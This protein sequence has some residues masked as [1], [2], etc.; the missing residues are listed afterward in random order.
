[1]TNPVHEETGR[2]LFAGVAAWATVVAAGAVEGLIGK[3][4]ADAVAAFAAAVSAYGYAVYR[5]DPNLRRYA[6]AS[7]MRRVYAAGLVLAV[8]LA[9]SAVANAPALAVFAAP[10][11]SIVLAAALD[12]R[13]A[14]PTKARAKSPGATRAAT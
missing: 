11:A 8:L 14:K 13:A 1:M 9:A 12:L 5:L 3:F 2:V 7:G 4:D 6:L 10:L